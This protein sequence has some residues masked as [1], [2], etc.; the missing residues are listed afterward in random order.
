MNSII[1]ALDATKLDIRPVQPNIVYRERLQAK[2]E[3]DQLL[4]EAKKHAAKIV[5]AAEEKAV[6]VFEQAKTD[7]LRLGQKEA[8]ANV[9]KA[10]QWKYLE[11]KRCQRQ[12]ADLATKIAGKIIAREIVIN[13]ETVVD[14]CR[15]VIKEN[16]SGQKLTAYV[17]SQDVQMLQKY[18]S[19]MVDDINAILEIKTSDEVSE[20]GCM[21]VG[22]LGR[23]DGR[24]EVQLEEITRKLLGLS[25][26]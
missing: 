4:A 20:G 6:L 26:E 24:I 13:D 1:P 21:V 7:G 5:T 10:V 22:E 8:A 18:K 12:L 14:I 9:T 16:L 2:K 23:V 17:R 11:A 15:A 19:S 3:A 25:H